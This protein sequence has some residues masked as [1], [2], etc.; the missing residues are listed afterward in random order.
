MILT[1]MNIFTR[2][3]NLAQTLIISAP[4]QQHR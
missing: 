1:Q 4:A 2:T 3:Q